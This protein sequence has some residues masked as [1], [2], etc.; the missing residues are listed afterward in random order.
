MLFVVVTD[1][2][3][4]FVVMVLFT[5]RI[6]AIYQRSGSKLTSD[7]ELC[8]K[9]AM[10]YRPEDTHKGPTF[11]GESDMCLLYWGDEGRS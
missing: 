1:D 7:P 4:S 5:G 3:I 9:L 8:V 6:R 11:S 2:F 10:F